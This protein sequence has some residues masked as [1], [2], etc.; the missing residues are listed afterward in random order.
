MTLSLL[1]LFISST[2]FSTWL[3]VKPKDNWFVGSFN[4]K[5]SVKIFAYKK[6]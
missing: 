3:N 4:A 6:N 1:L 2:I 5:E